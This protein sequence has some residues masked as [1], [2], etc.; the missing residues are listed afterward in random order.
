MFLFSLQFTSIEH[1]RKQKN[2]NQT[3]IENKRIII[4]NNK[5]HGKHIVSNNNANTETI[6]SCK[7]KQNK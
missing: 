4:Y 2:Q 6:G 3:Q 7:T 5:Q 1:E